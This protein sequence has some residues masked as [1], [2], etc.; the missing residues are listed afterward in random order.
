MTMLLL[1]CG[2]WATIHSQLITSESATP[3]WRFQYVLCLFLKQSNQTCYFIILCLFLG[4]SRQPQ[5]AVMLGSVHLELSPGNPVSS[6]IKSQSSVQNH[7]KNWSGLLQHFNCAV[8][9]RATRGGCSTVDLL[10]MHNLYYVVSC[11]F[12]RLA[13]MW[14]YIRRCPCLVC[15]TVLWQSA[16]S[17]GY[18]SSSIITHTLGDLWDLPLTLF[19]LCCVSFVRV[20]NVSLHSVFLNW[21]SLMHQLWL[22]FCFCFF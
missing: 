17:E 15:C 1:S 16:L 13:L 5:T 6:D 10:A 3:I 20:L 2:A 22:R 7:Y 18:F 12:Y 19:A 4:L 9:P 8:C 14:L 11:L 21:C